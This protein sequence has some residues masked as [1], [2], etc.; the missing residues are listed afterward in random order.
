VKVATG[1]S[2]Y[3]FDNLKLLRNEEKV[4]GIAEVR[5]LLASFEADS[6]FW[7]MPAYV[8]DAGFDGA[9]WLVE[10]KGENRYHYVSRWSPENGAIREI[11]TKFLTL[12]GLKEKSVY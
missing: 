2:G 5:D 10:A 1:K 9:T 7:R 6:P 11:G 8:A 12:S 3:D 4:V